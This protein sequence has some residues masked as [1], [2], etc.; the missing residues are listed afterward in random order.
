M[1]DLSPVRHPDPQRRARAPGHHPS[2]IN[3]KPVADRTVLYDEDVVRLVD[4]VR[5]PASQPVGATAQLAIVGRY[6][7]PLAIDGDAPRWPRPVVG[8]GQA[9]I[10][11]ASLKDPVVLYRQGN[12]LWCRAGSFDVD[13][14]ACA[15]RSAALQSSV[16]GDGFSFSLEPLGEHPV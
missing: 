8:T 16:L 3:G 10:P 1:G 15:G 13:G 12:A 5:F 2:F 9:H 6:R 7:L 4:R 11:A 14:R